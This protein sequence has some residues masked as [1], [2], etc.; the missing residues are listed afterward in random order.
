MFSTLG[1]LSKVLRTIL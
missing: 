1:M